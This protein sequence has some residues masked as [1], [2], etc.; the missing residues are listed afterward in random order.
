MALPYSDM[1]VANVSYQPF[2]RGWAVIIDEEHEKMH[3]IKDEVALGEDLSLWKSNK[4]TISDKIFIQQILRMFTTQDVVVG[5]FYYDILIPIFK[6]NEIRNM[7]GGFAAREKIHQA[8]YALLNNTLGL[9]ESDFAAFLEYKEMKDKAEFAL[10]ADPSTLEGL[11]KALAKGVFNEGVSLFA[12]F[13]MLLN[14]QRHGKMMGMCKIVEWSLKDETKHCEG[15]SKLFREVCEEFPYIVTD[16]FKRSIYDMAR[17][18]VKLEDAFVDLVYS[19]HDIEGLK[20][21]EVKEYVR[22]IAD[23]RLVQLGLKENFKVEHNPLPWLNW[24]I[25]APQHAN[26]FETRSADYEVAGLQGEWN[27][28][29]PKK[30]LIFTKDDCPWCLKAKELIIQHGHDYSEVDV[31]DYTKRQLFYDTYQLV[32]SKRSVPQIFDEDV[33]IGGYTELVKYLT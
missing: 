22:Y 29:E 4:I 3:W 12:S 13:V 19:E 17:E 28:E 14:F 2:L 5:S 15:V 7:L 31:S 27:Y 33:K 18:I 8:A 10:E 21:E 32:G 11:G 16:E 20:K 30:F 23:R 24:I 26:F 6:N 1:F 25:S 9:P